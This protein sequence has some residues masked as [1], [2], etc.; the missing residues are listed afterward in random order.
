MG[1]S[2]GVSSKGSYGIPLGKLKHPSIGIKS[3]KIRY[4]LANSNGRTGIGVWEDKW[5]IIVR[6]IRNSGR[7][8]KK[9][10]ARLTWHLV[11]VQ[12]TW[13]E[14]DWNEVF[15]SGDKLRIKNLKDRAKREARKRSL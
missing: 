15:K 1:E 9:L 14:K 5:P 8:N 13:K 2:D 4:S 12:P 11:P 10:C 3:L 7:D 6:A